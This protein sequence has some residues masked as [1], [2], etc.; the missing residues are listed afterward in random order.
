MCGIAGLALRSSER[1]EGSRVRRVLDKLEHRG[2]DDSGLLYFNKGKVT[3]GRR[4][5][6]S[7]VVS[8]VVLLHRRLS[9]L[10]LSESGWQPMGTPDGTYFIVFNGEIYNYLELRTELENLGYQFQSRSDTEVLLYAYV[11]W[12]AQALT[13]LVGMFAFAILNIQERRLFIARDF[14][15]IKPLYYAWTSNGLAFASEIKALLE[16]SG[17]SREINPQRLYD[18]LRFGITDQGSDTL[19]KNIKQLPSAHYLDVALGDVSNLRSQPIRYWQVDMNQQVDLSFDQAAERVRELFL[20]NISLHLRSDVPIGIALS[21]GIDSSAIAMAMRQLNPNLEIHAFSYVAENSALSEEHWVDLVGREA[22]L[23]VHKVVPKAEELV[24]DLDQ[25][26]GVQEESFGSTSIYAQ[27]R[28]FQR[29]HEVGIKVMLDGQ[30]AD[31]IFGGYTFYI[32]ARFGSLVRSGKWGE[33][34]RLLNSASTL[35]GMSA[36]GLCLRSMDFVL[37]VALQKPLRR[38]INK[39][40]L[41]PWLNAHWFLER[42]VVI[43]SPGYKGGNEIL[44]GCLYDNLVET[45]LPHLLRYEDRNSMAFSIESRVPFLTPSL[46]NFMF[47]LPEEY[48]ISPNGTTKAVFRKAMQGIVPDAI[49]ARKDKIG[50]GTP[51]RDWLMRLRPWIN[52][53]LNGEAVSQIPALNMKEF[54]R[55]WEAV[56]QG[57]RPFDFHVWRCVNFI[58]WSQKFAVQI[59]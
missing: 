17:V 39:D 23:V 32:A 42:G 34:F 53:I 37:P 28:V 36:L 11:E 58:I 22:N 5:N 46:V 29:A 24:E 1:I 4:K 18:Y 12:G 51:E 25:L 13:R 31:E 41:P 3:L 40:L 15:G 30:G 57:S 21:G 33:A 14:F 26:I 35:P 16:L 45:N 50:F 47:S 55:E 38:L 8:E 20:E 10:D 2:P 49:L 52:R 43:R 6:P 7:D 54:S 44:K 19:F 48:F 27:R 59:E 9:I 56:I